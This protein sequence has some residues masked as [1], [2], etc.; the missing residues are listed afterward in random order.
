MN[1]LALTSI[2]LSKASDSVSH[3]VLLTELHW[4]GIDHRRFQSYLVSRNQVVTGGSR[5]LPLTH[6][7]IKAPLL[8]PFSSVYSLTIFLRTCPVDT[9]CRML[10]T[11][12]SWA[13]RIPMTPL[14]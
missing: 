5:H 1:I 3:D 11:L 7:V 8:D 2:D 10:T 9:W 6:G 12:S 13:Q 14:F 4:Y